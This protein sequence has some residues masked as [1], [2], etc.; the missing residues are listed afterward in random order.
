MVQEGEKHKAADE[1]RRELIE[2]KNRVE[3]MIHETEKQVEN[4][5]DQLSS[6]KIESINSKLQDL[7][8]AM[9]SDSITS[10]EL[11]EKWQALQNDTMEVFS[12]AYKKNASE[13]PENQQSEE[14][15]S[16]D[17]QKKEDKN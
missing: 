10:S 5:K 4:F 1:E 3:S 6:D 12:E 7:R 17:S 14:A 11:R 13:N 9:N 2:E 8:E 15:K 16:D